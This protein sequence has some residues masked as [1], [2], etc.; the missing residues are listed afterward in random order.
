MNKTFLRTAK[1][2]MSGSLWNETLIYKAHPGKPRIKTKQKNLFRVKLYPEACLL[3]PAVSVTSVW[4]PASPRAI[5]K[6]SV[7]NCCCAQHKM[8]FSSQKSNINVIIHLTIYPNNAFM[9]IEGNMTSI[10]WSQLKNNEVYELESDSPCILKVSAKDL[11]E[12]LWFVC[13]EQETLKP[14]SSQASI[15]YDIDKKATYRT[16]TKKLLFCPSPHLIH[17]T[18]WQ[19]VCIYTRTYVSLSRTGKTN[20]KNF[21]L[22]LPPAWELKCLNCE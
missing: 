7:N 13:I 10:K 18:R 1:L 6:S 4:N 16:W 8:Y 17:L 3:F 19:L 21:P 2:K 9:E 14:L 22:L 15:C 11:T 12:L 20:K 5:Y